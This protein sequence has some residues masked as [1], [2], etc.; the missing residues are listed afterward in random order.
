MVALAVGV[1]AQ[2][3]SL[4]LRQ[5]LVEGGLDVPELLRRDHDLGRVEDAG[6]REHVHQDAVRVLL[7][8]QWLGQRDVGVERLVL[9]APCAADRRD[10]LARDADVGEGPE[11]RLLVRLE[12]SDGLVQADHRLLEDVVALGAD[13]EIGAGFHS[14]EVPVAGEE[15]LGGP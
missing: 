6:P 13:Q 1:Q 4:E 10:E 9:L 12:I 15:A 3:L 14:S 2:H 11:R 5:Q 7:R 8:R